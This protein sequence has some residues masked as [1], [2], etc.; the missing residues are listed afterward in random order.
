[1]DGV[2]TE[3]VLD[4]AGGLPEVIVA[5]TGGA[6]T[7]YVQVQGQVLAQYDA[8]AWVY[9]L[10][11]HLGSVR[12]LVDAAGQVTL[13]QGYDPFGVLNSQHGTQNPQLPFGYTG[14]WWD[15]EAALLYLRARYYDP[16]VGR[17]VTR[18]AWEG[19]YQRPLTLN[20]YLYALANP[21]NYEDPYG[22]APLPVMPPCVDVALLPDGYYENLGWAIAFGLGVPGFGTFARDDLPMMVIEPLASAYNT[23]VGGVQIVYDYEHKQ[24]AVFRY[25]GVAWDP[26]Q[27][28]G[29]EGIYG[30]GFIW[31]FRQRGLIDYEGVT[32]DLAVGLGSSVSVIGFGIEGGMAPVLSLS[33]SDQGEVL[34]DKPIGIGLSASA[35]VGVSIP[36]PIVVPLPTE[37]GA[38]GNV[39]LARTTMDRET[40]EPYSNAEMMSLAIQNSGAILMAQAHQALFGMPTNWSLFLQSVLG[41]QY[42]SPLHM[43]DLG[44]RS[45]AGEL[46]YLYER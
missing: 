31:G 17:F 44:L 15:A 30:Q 11:D 36:S 45:Q 16:A 42:Y 19:K 13:A 22:L 1:V 43:R 40:L 10:P 39:A 24:S 37:E 41:Y 7:R 27:L 21:A 38:G 18:D 20:P 14:E 35:E 3:Y 25:F 2:T 29:V 46:P 32:M 9:I 5:T 4:V 28:A 33:L 12:Q 26:L 6:S 34:L 8:G 23:V